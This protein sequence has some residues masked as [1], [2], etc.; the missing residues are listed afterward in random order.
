M[1]DS[2]GS[3]IIGARSQDPADTKEYRTMNRK[4][5]FLV[6]AATLSVPV[7][8]VAATP[9][10]AATPTHSAH[11]V[12]QHIVKRYDDSRETSK[13]NSKERS[14][15]DATKDSSRRDPSHDTAKD[16]PRDTSP[17]PDRRD[18]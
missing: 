5:A 6:A 3:S 13:D 16:S 2:L 7:A 14:S 8:A 12:T 1:V 17:S 10:F 15:A 9:A 4:M 18:S 11:V